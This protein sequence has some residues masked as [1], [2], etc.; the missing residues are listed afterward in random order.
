MT[1]YQWFLCALLLSSC[2]GTRATSYEFCTLAR[3]G[4]A[5]DGALVETRAIGLFGD[6]GVSLTGHR[7][8]NE[9]VEWS[10]ANDFPASDGAQ[11]LSDAISQTRR[12]PLNPRSIEL[13]VVGRLSW[14]AEGVRPRAAIE[15][16]HVSEIQLVEEL[17]H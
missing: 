15:V 11:A 5:A 10:E 12:D 1:R 16:Q 6:H 2:G 17:P 13:T 9:F 4:E 7:C 14:R 3:N 8:P